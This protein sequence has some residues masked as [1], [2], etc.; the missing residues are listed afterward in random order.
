MAPRDSTAKDREETA[1]RGGEGVT[2][3]D[4]VPPRWEA[5]SY[6]RRPIK[7]STMWL[8]GKRRDDDIGELW[9]IHDKLYDLTDFIKMHPGGPDW[10]TLTRGTDITEAFE[11]HHL[12]ERP[13]RMLERFFVREASGPR[14]SAYTFAKDGFYNILKERVRKELAVKDNTRHL[15]PTLRTK[16][17]ADFLLISTLVAGCLASNYYNSPTLGASIYYMFM[18][19]SGVMLTLLTISGHNFFHQRD[20]L[21]VL[22]FDLSLM[23]SRDWRVSHALSHHLF[24]NT[25]LDLEVCLFEPFVE[26]L[27]N[28]KKGFVIRYVSWIYSPILWAVIFYA[29]K[30]K[31]ILSRELEWKD[32]IP[33]IIP[34]TFWASTGFSP[35]CIRGAIYT[36]LSVIAVSSFLFGYIGLNAGHHHPEVFHAGDTPRKDNDWGLAQV[37]AIMDRVEVCNGIQ[38]FSLVTFGN[39]TLHHLFPTI[40]NAHL[41]KLYPVLIQTCEEFGKNFSF[42]NLWETTKGQFLQ[43]ANNRPNPKPPK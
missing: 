16:L 24:P 19:V 4:A 43:M 3:A 1:T 35:D 33:L 20:S 25:K 36:W 42:G 14:N 34:L 37:D 22:Y 40:D 38:E 23:S 30:L 6:R 28:P 21:R 31:R 12:S 9:R 7:G 41:A 15:G 29:E 32:A 26:W 2:G 11:S 13:T 18:A 27:P 10:L 5:P 8:K 39:H 17:A